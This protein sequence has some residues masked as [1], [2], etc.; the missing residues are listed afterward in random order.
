MADR[1][2]RS[3]SVGI[4]HTV[5][6]RPTKAN[7]HPCRDAAGDRRRSL[8]AAVRRKWR[9]R[10]CPAHQPSR[11]GGHFVR[12]MTSVRTPE[13]VGGGYVGAKRHGWSPFRWPR[14]SPAPG[15][16]PSRPVRLCPSGRYWSVIMAGVGRDRAA[17]SFVVSCGQVHAK[18]MNLAALHSTPRQHHQHQPQQHQQHPT[19][20][21]RWFQSR[22]GPGGAAALSSGQATVA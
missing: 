5:N 15:R 9:R 1:M 4:N 8:N 16:S 22:S 17:F 14:S 2:R 12:G 21:P 11:H 6:Q 19:Q 20:T 10:R 13:C 18:S 7:G 3:D